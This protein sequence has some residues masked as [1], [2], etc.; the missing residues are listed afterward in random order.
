MTNAFYFID[1]LF[2][3][4]CV[5]QNPCIKAAG[6]DIW[7]L[8]CQLIASDKW[9]CSGRSGAIENTRKIAKSGFC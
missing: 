1:Q 9:T 8:I 7:K 2:K 3:V 5:W 6:T 4:L